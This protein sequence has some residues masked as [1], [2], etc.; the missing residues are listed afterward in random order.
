LVV[1][2]YDV[3]AVADAIYKACTM[4]PQEK[5][6]RLALLQERIRARD[7]H[8]WMEEFLDAARGPA[9]ATPRRDP[10][11]GDSARLIDVEGPRRIPAPSSL[12]RP[13]VP[14]LLRAADPTPPGGSASRPA[15]C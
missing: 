6:R 13:P 15:A 5:A 11:F 14:R 4:D 1:N 9:E 12:R 10:A 7:V 8:R 3:E 2:P